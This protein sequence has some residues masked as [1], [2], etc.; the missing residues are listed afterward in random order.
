MNELGFVKP[1]IIQSFSIPLIAKEPYNALIAQARNG[2]GKT[3]SFSIGSTLRVDR[4]D[5][6]IQVLVITHTRE[7][8]NQVYAV[9]EKIT[10]GTGITIGNMAENNKTGQIMIGTHGKVE[11]SVSGRKTMDLSGLRCLVADE[12]DVFF[13]DDKNYECLMKIANSKHIKDNANIQWVL[14]S[15]TFPPELDGKYE[16]VQERMSSIV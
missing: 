15:A 5:P 1:S 2:A 12:A 4:K 7:L 6:K 10:K 8:C 11:K 9:Y 14:F 3:G 13:L 16:K